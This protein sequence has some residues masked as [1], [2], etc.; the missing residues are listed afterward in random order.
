[1][2][3]SIILFIAL[4]SCSNPNGKPGQASDTTR[5]TGIGRKSA[6]PIEDLLQ[7]RAFVHFDTTAFI[8]ADSL[9]KRAI[10]TSFPNDLGGLKMN[11]ISAIKLTEKDI[12]GSQSQTFD[13]YEIIFSSDAPSI[14]GPS[15]YILISRN[16][17]K[18]VLLPFND[19]KIL[20]L[21][22][23]KK[24]LLIGGLLTSQGKGFYMIYRYNDST[25]FKLIFNTAD[26]FTCGSSIPVYNSSTDCISYDPYL[27][28]LNITDVNKD[29]IKDLVFTGKVLYF[30][31]GLE[32]G[33]GRED[34]KPL[35]QKNIKL[36]F[37]TVI[38]AD[39]I[40]WQLSDTS[41][42]RTITGQ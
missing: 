7:F 31:K 40:S 37:Q 18:A 39:N 2:N 28:H 38:N 35:R 8:G 10:I 23:A 27:L 13:A 42:C 21:S 1:M 19:F 4:L 20:D 12:P 5:T 9:L 33:I 32:T 26:D 30:C 17:A 11:D 16:T 22:L 6:V 25:G 14:T 29:H 15:Q 36:I 41:V 3:R 24:P 34:R